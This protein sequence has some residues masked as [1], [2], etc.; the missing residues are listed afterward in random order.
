MSSNNPSQLLPSGPFSYG[1][2]F[3]TWF[4]WTNF[5]ES[6]WILCYCISIFVD[7]DFFCV[8]SLLC[9]LLFRVDRPMYRVENMGDNEG[10]QGAGGYPTRL[11]C[12]CEYGV[13]RCYWIVSFLFLLGLFVCNRG[14]S[15]S[16]RSNLKVLLL[17]YGS[18]WVVDFVLL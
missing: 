1:A 5:E 13:G 2:H 10:R 9:S 14:W 7:F 11:R 18:E 6:A 4:G 17:N 12:V 8:F 15:V 3:F 16:K